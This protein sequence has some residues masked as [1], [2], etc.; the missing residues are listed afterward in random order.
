VAEDLISADMIPGKFSANVA[1]TSEYFFRGVSQT[2]DSPAIQGG[3]DWNH[4]GTGLYAGVWGS[5]VDFN[6]G[7]S[8][9]IDIYGGIGG[10]INKFSWKV[11]GLWYAYPDDP[12]GVTYDYGEL[13]ASVGYDFGLLNAGFS[14]YYSPDFFGESGHAEYYAFNV[15]IPIKMFTLN[16]VAGRQNIEKN[17]VFLLP[18][19]WHYGAS[20]STVVAGFTL[21]LGVTD[22]DM[23]DDECPDL[24]GASVIFTVSRSF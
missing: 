5:N 16:L 19:Y 9:E 12:P 1:F 6:T 7:N 10:A 20:I 23:E 11:G 18:D 2:D 24:C 14:F 15:G 22:T 13:M 4:E 3:F 8:V 17:D 21:S